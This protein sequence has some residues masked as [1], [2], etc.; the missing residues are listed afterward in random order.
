MLPNQV[1][2]VEVGARDGLQNEPG[3]VVATEIKLG[4]IERLEQAG[5][6]YI[7]AASFVSP[8]WVPQ[9]GDATAV[10]TGINPKDGVTYAALTPNLKG[11]EAAMAG[12]RERSGNLAAPRRR[13]SRRRTSTARLPKACS[14]SRR[15]WPAPPR[16]RSA[17]AV[18]SRP[19][20]AALTRA[21]SPRPRLPR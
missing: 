11:F 8:K 16:R 15:S 9:M 17:C 20:S 2:I 4:L 7:E 12:W 1:R 19:C 18:M 13:A 6:S 21:R 14:A 3:D 10:M 5:V